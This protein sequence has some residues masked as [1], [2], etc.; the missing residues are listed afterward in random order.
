M[1][2]NG[3]LSEEQQ[4]SIIIGFAANDNQL[5]SST[6]AAKERKA[7][8]EQAEEQPHVY[9]KTP[10]G[11]IEDRCRDL[12]ITAGNRISSIREEP[13][14]FAHTKSVAIDILNCQFVQ[15][16]DAASAIPTPLFAVRSQDEYYPCHQHGIYH[17]DLVS[18]YEALYHSQRKQIQSRIISD[19][20]KNMPVLGS[21]IICIMPDTVDDFNSSFRKQ[22]AAMFQV[23]RSIAA[24]YAQSVL[25]P[26][27]SLSNSVLCLDYDG[28]GVSA[29][30]IERIDLDGTELLL[31]KGR[32]KILGD[33]PSYR[34]NII[35][36][37]WNVITCQKRKISGGKK[38]Q[39]DNTAPVSDAVRSSI[40]GIGAFL[41]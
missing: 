20:I 39:N 10:R 22:C 2:S 6:E 36:M 37:F 30:Q 13:H 12:A 21:D 27:E 1:S 33:H 11:I 9:A 31:R 17:E 8:S 23:P 18:T 34:S 15:L 24:V 19:T 4:K 28:E 40:T 29:V 7:K 5:D 32:K 26:K 14:K 25:L 16:S 3:V 41:F 35:S 38:A